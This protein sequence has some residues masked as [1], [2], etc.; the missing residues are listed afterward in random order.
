[1]S[2]AGLRRL[3][4][5]Y[6][7]GLPITGLEDA[8]Q[9]AVV[10]H[11]GTKLGDDGTVFTNGGRVLGVTATGPDLNAAIDSAYAAAG[12]IHFQDMHFRTDIGRV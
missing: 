11:A 4:R 9:Q 8:G 12:H 10:F 3:P 5:L 2:G 7:K 1:M 6:A